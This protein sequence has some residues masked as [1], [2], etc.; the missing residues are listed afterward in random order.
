MHN[1]FFKKCLFEYENHFTVEKKH[2]KFL[3]AISKILRHQKNA[4]HTISISFLFSTIHQNLCQNKRKVL[5]KI[6]D[7]I[8]AKCMKFV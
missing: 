6:D 4:S 5:R 7:T 1:F 2:K 3:R 8:L